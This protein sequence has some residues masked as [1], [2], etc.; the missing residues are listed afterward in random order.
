MLYRAA[1]LCAGIAVFAPGAQAQT[2]YYPMPPAV[3]PALP[4]AGSEAADIAACMCLRQAVDVLG[5]DM[6]ARRQ[7][8]DQTQAELGRI[9]AQLEQERGTIDVNNPA[10][11]SRFRQ[12]LGERDALFRRSAGAM[13]SD[14]SSVTDRYNARV[15]EYNGRCADR[16]RPP[17]LVAQVQAT[18]TCP[19]P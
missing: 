10:S 7:A 8:Y 11:V 3:A 18:L 15:G 13:F 9:D 12:L 6:T 14:L 16:P 2:P 19:P 4:P 17:G 5:A 1:A